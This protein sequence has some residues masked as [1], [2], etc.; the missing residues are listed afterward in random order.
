[1]GHRYATFVLPEAGRAFYST[2][3]AKRGKLFLLTTNVSGSHASQFTV[4][5]KA[6]PLAKIDHHFRVSGELFTW[7]LADGRLVTTEGRNGKGIS[8]NGINAQE[9]PEGVV[10]RVYDPEKRR[11]TPLDTVVLGVSYTGRYLAVSPDGLK[12][13]RMMRLEEGAPTE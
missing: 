7:C 10:S 3:A 11:W 1:M 2:E 5:K 13:V 6:L 12:S 9:F 4:V 8:S